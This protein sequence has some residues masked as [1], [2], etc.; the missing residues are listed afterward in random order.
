MKRATVRIYAW[1]RLFIV[2]HVSK[3][4]GAVIL[5]GGGGGGGGG[6]GRGGGGGGRGVA[7]RIARGAHQGHFVIPCYERDLNSMLSLFEILVQKERIQ[8]AL[9]FEI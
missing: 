8:D 2:R 7:N 3:A 4:V 1:N 6:G 9:G 5:H